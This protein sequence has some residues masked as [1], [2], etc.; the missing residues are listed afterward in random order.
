MKSSAHH[1]LIPQCSILLMILKPVF[2]LHRCLKEFSRAEARGNPT[3]QEQSWTTVYVFPDGPCLH[4]RE[5]TKPIGD[6]DESSLHI[7]R[8]HSEFLFKEFSVQKPI[9]SQHPMHVPFCRCLTCMELTKGA[10]YTSEQLCIASKR[11]DHVSLH[12]A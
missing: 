11:E 5:A 6:T 4:T 7:S 9:V 3:P 12:R 8:T 10:K 2:S 1:R